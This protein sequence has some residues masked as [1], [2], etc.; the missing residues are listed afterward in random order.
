MDFLTA[1][2]SAPPT[3]IKEDQKDI[4]NPKFRIWFCQDKL[5]HNAI[6]SS[7]DLTLASMVASASN[8]QEAW[9]S[10]HL[11]FAN[12]SQTRVFSLRDQLGRLTRQNKSVSEYLR[13]I[14][15]IC[16][17]LVIAGSPTSNAELTVKILRTR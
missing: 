9:N 16:D 7:V 1:Q 8:S 14:R 13:E 4:P 3:T 11:A 10:L 15:A 6:L 17:E 5:I 12:K 2:R